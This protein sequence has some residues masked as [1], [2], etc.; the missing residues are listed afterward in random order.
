M[1]E[2]CMDGG[3]RMMEGCMQDVPKEEQDGGMF[4][5]RMDELMYLCWERMEGCM[6]ERCINGGGLRSEEQ[7]A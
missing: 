3:L 1:Y 7:E 4:A 5:S 6:Y 2:R